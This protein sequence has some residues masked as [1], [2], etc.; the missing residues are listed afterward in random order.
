[1]EIYEVLY[2]LPAADVEVSDM[3]RFPFLNEDGESYEEVVVIDEIDY[4][5]VY[6]IVSGFSSV[7]NVNDEFH[8]HE[9]TIVDVLGG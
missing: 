6:V 7:L 9:D 5:G 2:S 3:I 4:S 8:I 1:M